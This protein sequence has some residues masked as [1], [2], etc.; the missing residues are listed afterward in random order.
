MNRRHCSLSVRGEALGALHAFLYVSDAARP[1]PCRDNRAN[2]DASDRSPTVTPSGYVGTGS[3]TG[4]SESADERRKPRGNDGTR[5]F[6]DRSNGHLAWPVETAPRWVESPDK[7]P[8][9]PRT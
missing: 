5:R 8:A 2:S 6:E 4:T 7:D 3:D 9:P 1:R